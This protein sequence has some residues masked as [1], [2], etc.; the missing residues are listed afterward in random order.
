MKQVGIVGWWGMVG[1]VLLQCMIEENDF[2]D[3]LV[4]FFSIFSVGVVGLVIKGKSDKLKD[5]NFFSVF[6]EMDI[7]IICQGGDYIKVIYFVLINFGW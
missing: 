3:I 1:L 5:V 6:V 2:D 4:Y 7:I